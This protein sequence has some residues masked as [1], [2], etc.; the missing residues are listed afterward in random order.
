MPNL[1][2]D[3]GPEDD[4]RSRLMRG[5]AMAVAEK[6]YGDTTIADVVRH[7]RVSKRTFYEHFSSKE[8]CL[9]AVYVA[10]RGLTLKAIA[11]AVEESPN[12]ETR[13]ER[14]TAAFLNQL[15]RAPLLV[16]AL[17][18]D[19]LALGAKGLQLRRQTN[20]RFADLL[21]Q[22]AKEEQKKKPG[23]KG[24]TAEMAMAV[25]GGITELILKAVEEDRVEQLS[26]LADPI[27]DFIRVVA[28]HI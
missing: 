7:A 5:M 6:G 9:L 26:E 20:Q 11:T 19:I 22:L 3:Y 4:Y 23:G 21:Q 2:E 25:V 28:D 10:A 8:D 17:Y 16:R 18:V 15:Q 24:L 1:L 27:N 14:A 13:I 12:E